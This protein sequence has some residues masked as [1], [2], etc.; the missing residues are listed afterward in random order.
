MYTNNNEYEKKMIEAFVNKPEKTL[1][2][3]NAF[4]KFDIN[5]I[6]SMKW[7]WSWWAFGGGWA[8]LLYRKQ[9]IPA[10]VLF[11]LSVITG[12]IPF[13]SI[14]LMILSG[15]FSTYFVYKGYKNKKEEIES[16]I[17]DINKRIETMREVGGYNQWVVWVYALFSAFILL[18]I[19]AAVATLVTPQ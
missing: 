10:I 13:A 1:W 3:Q 16:K 2:Y 17:D 8:F 4:S 15:G 5:G 6:D 11:I 9:Y 12:A 14:L 18:Y 7:V 19:V